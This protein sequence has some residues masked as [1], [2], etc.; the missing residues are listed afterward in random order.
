[1][2]NWSKMKNPGAVKTNIFPLAM[3]SLV[4]TTDEGSHQPHTHTHTPQSTET[5]TWL[6]IPVW[7]VQLQILTSLMNFSIKEC[8][9]KKKKSVTLKVDDLLPVTRCSFALHSCL[10]GEPSLFLSRNKLQCS[11]LH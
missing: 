2:I 7:A 4:A 3:I 1:M 10:L 11:F 6:F 5:H 8:D 9:F